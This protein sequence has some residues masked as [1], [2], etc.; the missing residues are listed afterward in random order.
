MTLFE[1]LDINP[2]NHVFREVLI[3]ISKKE[4]IMS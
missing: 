3:Y 4:K 1:S 2:F